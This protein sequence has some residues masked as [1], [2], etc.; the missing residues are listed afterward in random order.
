[1]A[2]AATEPLA[3]TCGNEKLSQDQ[4]YVENITFVDCTDR[5]TSS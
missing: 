4:K 2:C 5:T 1:M 3:L